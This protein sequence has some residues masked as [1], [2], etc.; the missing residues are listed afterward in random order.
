MSEEYDHDDHGY[1]LEDVCDRLDNIEE[2]L[3]TNH[4]NFSWVGFLLI[5]W[6]AL[7]GFGDM[8]NSKLRYSWS[9]NVGYDQV[10]IEKKPTN[11][12]FFH[13]PLGEK[14]CHYDR[15]VSTIKVKTENSDP[16]R[17]PVNYLSFDEGKTWTVDDASPPTKPRVI[18]SWEKVEEYE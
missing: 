16:A 13:A 11:C 9:Y 6:F 17:Y 12:N 14:D 1:S 5:G 7:A 2:A 18:V 15:R 3:R 10:T 4:Q 8:W